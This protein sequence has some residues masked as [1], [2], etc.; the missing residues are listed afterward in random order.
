MNTNG[1]REKNKYLRK[2]NHYLQEEIEGLKYHIIKMTER[3]CARDM[4]REKNDRKG[5]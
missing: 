4:E 5:N 2:E 1:V 3:Q